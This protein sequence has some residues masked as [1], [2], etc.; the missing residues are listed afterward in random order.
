MSD[1][2]ITGNK[3][4]QHGIRLS[5]PPCK[6][7]INKQSLQRMATQPQKEKYRQ[8]HTEKNEKMKTEMKAREGSKRNEDIYTH[9]LKKKTEEK[10]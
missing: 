9:R 8:Q 1:H 10:S 5:A 6:R 7:R 3:S 4:Q 2:K